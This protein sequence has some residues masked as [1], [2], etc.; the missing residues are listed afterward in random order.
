M[1]RS[2]GFILALGSSLLL[3]ATPAWATHRI[4]SWT[5]PTTNEDGTPLTD[6]A[7]YR[8]YR[9]AVT[10]CTRAAGTLIATVTAPTTSFALP[11]GWQGYLTVTA[12]DT[13]GNESVEDGTAPFDGLAPSPATGL[14]VR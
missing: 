8:V 13:S 1:V 6:L 5:A 10:P 14:E 4:A 11:H 7:G 3:L 2:L 12:V 9:C